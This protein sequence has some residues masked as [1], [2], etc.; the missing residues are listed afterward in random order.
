[1]LI[2]DKKKIANSPGMTASVKLTILFQTNEFVSDFMGKFFKTR[3][4]GLAQVIFSIKSS[5]HLCCDAMEATSYF[6]M[7][8]F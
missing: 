8:S 7:I 4:L 3:Q 1:M 6:Q 5:T 2:L